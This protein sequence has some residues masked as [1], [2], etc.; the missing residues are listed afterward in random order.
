MAALQYVGDEACSRCHPQIARTY[1][2]HPMAHSCAPVSARKDKGGGM[3]DETPGSLSSFISQP[4]SFEAAG[5]QFV[6]EPR[7]QKIFHKTTRL[8]SERHPLAHSEI[9]VH[10]IIGAGIR[11]RSYLANRDGYLFQ[12]P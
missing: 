8:D 3:K 7:D 2:Q 10:F 4:S 6:V 11:G 1:H 5:L 9:E 12:S